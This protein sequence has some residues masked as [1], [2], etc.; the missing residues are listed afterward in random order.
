MNGVPSPGW[1]TWEH[2]SLIQVPN[3][4]EVVI[5]E[6]LERALELSEVKGNTSENINGP[7]VR[8]DLTFHPKLPQT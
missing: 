6:I 8:W 5:T 3:C 7:I 4:L 1:E 2:V